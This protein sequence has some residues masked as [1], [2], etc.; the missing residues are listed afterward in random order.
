MLIRLADTS[1]GP[2][3]FVPT[4]SI[5]YYSGRV[6]LRETLDDEMLRKE[7]SAMNIDGTPVGFSNGWYIRK[8]GT[9]SWIK[10]G[11]STARE[12]DFAT[13]LDTTEL[14]N[15]TYQVL[16]FMSAKIRT[17]GM[18][19]VIVSRQNIADFEIRN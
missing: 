14:E 13:R 15:G 18:K 9:Q 8:K 2:Q 10:I 5:K 11:E 7:L 3:F 17:P 6:L 4:I 19:D 1:W 16:G 12:H